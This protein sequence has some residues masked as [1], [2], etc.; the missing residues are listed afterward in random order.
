ML[1]DRLD[2]SDLFLLVEACAAELLVDACKFL[3]FNCLVDS[4]NR[5]A[6]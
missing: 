4:S 2:C 5:Y 3:L 1:D 6:C